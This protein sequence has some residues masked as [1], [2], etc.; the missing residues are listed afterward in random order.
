MQAKDLAVVECCCTEL[1]R[2]ASIDLFWQP[3]FQKEFGFVTS[4]ESYQAIQRGWQHV[5]ALK[6]VDRCVGSATVPCY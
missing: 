6:Y 2:L 1:R 5:Y 3:L 4:Y